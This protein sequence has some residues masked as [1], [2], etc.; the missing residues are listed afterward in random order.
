MNES[1]V[2]ENLINQFTNN[3]RDYA[4]LQLP[5]TD[6]LIFFQFSSNVSV[7]FMLK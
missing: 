4:C 3:R 1:T 5:K 2:E 6:D 7:V